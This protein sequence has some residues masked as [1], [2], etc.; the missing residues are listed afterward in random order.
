MSPRGLTVDVMDLLARLRSA[1]SSPEEQELLAVALNAM[2][3]ITS[4][5]Q[6]YAFTDFLEDLESNAPPTVVAA[7]NTRAEATDWLNNHPAPPDSA[8]VL[9]ADQYHLLL[10]LRETNHRH[11][12]PLPVLEYHL[13][14]L[15]R[16]GLPEAVAA[17][18]TRE[19]AEAWLER[20]SAPPR[21]AVVT[22]AGEP[23]LAVFHPNVGHRALHA[24]SLAREEDEADESEPPPRA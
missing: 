18:K 7:F 13:G 17:F 8:L 21:Q 19:E 20:Q 1:T 11:L 16:A 10:Y 24:F 14:R 6:R 22:I 2:L 15:R 23:F 4:T 12:S 9:I 5:G 3:F